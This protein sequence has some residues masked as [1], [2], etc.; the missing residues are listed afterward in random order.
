MKKN[1]LTYIFVLICIAMAQQVK[2][3]THYEPRIAVGGK[4]GMTMS[5]VMFSPSVPQK[6]LSGFMAGVAFRYAEEKNFGLLVELNLEQRGWQEDFEEAPFEYTRR[7]T[8]IQLPIMTHIFFGSTKVRG[9]FN[10]GPEIGFMIGES[11]T[12]NFD[13]N[14]FAGIEGFP[15]SNRYTEQFALPV[16]NKIDYGICVGAGME[17][18]AARKHSILLEGRFYYGLGNAFGSRKKDPFSASTGMSIMVTL[19]YMFRLK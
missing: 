12:A 4:A 5:K 2:A 7:L 11:T 6:M 15:T 10:A 14:D 9:F 16:K 3:Q 19:G 17:F 8:Y 1:I 13:V 18:I